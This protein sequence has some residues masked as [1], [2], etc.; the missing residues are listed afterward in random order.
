MERKSSQRIT[1][2]FLVRHA[3]VRSSLHLLSQHVSSTPVS[4]YF[5]F[6]WAQLKIIGCTW[7]L[8]LFDVATN[9]RHAIIRD[10]KCFLSIVYLHTNERS[11]NVPGSNLEIWVWRAEVKHPH[12]TRPELN[13]TTQSSRLGTTKPPTVSERSA[14]RV[15]G[16]KDWRPIFI[17][18]NE[19]KEKV[20]LSWLPCILPDASGESSRCLLACPTGEFFQAGLQGIFYLC[21]TSHLLRPDTEQSTGNHVGEIMQNFWRLDKICSSVQ[22]FD[23]QYLFMLPKHKTASP[24][25][26]AISAHILPICL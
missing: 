18:R 20:N 6:A 22:I 24:S 19:E 15:T 21:F 17:L 14:H 2:A 3:L 26:N 5:S 4:A 9:S 25:L 13:H 1:S 10:K 12:T 11:H 16:T 7:I 23:V 8:R